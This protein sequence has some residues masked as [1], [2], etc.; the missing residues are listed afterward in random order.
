MSDYTELVRLAKRGRRAERT[1]KAISRFVGTQLAYGIASLLNGWLLMLAVGVI[2]M[3][4]IPALPT[5]GY[6]WAVLIVWL[7]AGTFSRQQMPKDS[8]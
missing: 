3:H 4:W 7:L 1:G 2:H 6:W 8:S 5:V